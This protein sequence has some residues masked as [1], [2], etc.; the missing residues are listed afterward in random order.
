[1]STLTDKKPV[2]MAYEGSKTRHNL[3]VI[4]FFL[5]LNILLAFIFTWSNGFQHA[6]AVAATSVGAHAMS[7]HRTIW[8]IAVFEFLGTCFGGSAV[9]QVVQ[10]LSEWPARPTLLPILAAALLTATAWNFVARVLKVSASST[11]SLLGGLMGALFAAS[12]NFGYIRPGEFDIVHPNGVIGAFISLFLSP[13]LGYVIAYL[14]FCIGLVCALRATN[15]LARYLNKCQP[16]LTALVAFGDGANDTQKTMG[17]LVLALNASGIMSLQDIPVWMRLLIGLAMASGA[18]FINSG[19]VNE[20][21]FDIFKIKP[22]NAFTAN[23][24]SACVLIGNTIVGGPVSAS[25]VVAASIIGTGAA[26]RQR[27]IHWLIIKDLLLSWLITI[28]ANALIAS[29]FY[30]LLFKTL[31]ANL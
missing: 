15:R 4:S 16:V 24:S 22:L 21:A 26:S 9:A 2:L 17:L 13:F 30:L 7:R 29:G 6:S 25:Q 28:P 31:S 23:L 8:I 11:H 1:M 18:F 27:G 10:G 5:L 19:L 20:L 12:S 14:F 3:I